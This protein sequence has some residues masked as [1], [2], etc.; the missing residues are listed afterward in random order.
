MISLTSRNLFI[1]LPNLGYSL[2]GVEKQFENF[3]LLHVSKVNYIISPM[4][5]VPGNHPNFLE[6]NHFLAF[7]T[8]AGFFL[9]PPIISN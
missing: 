1:R 7:D 4:I 6:L 8:N 9:K 5:T 2:I 3:Y